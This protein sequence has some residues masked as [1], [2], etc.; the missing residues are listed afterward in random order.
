MLVLRV[1][2][3]TVGSTAMLL[4]LTLTAAFTLSLISGLNIIAL[5]LAYSP[6]GLTEMSLVALSLQ[7]E[8]A[9]VAFHHIAR[10]LIVVTIASGLFRY[11]KKFL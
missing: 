6:G 8:V 11:A 5:M 4:V 10:V 1:I 2:A 9:F 3:L 7:I